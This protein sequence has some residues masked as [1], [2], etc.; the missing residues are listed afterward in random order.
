MHLLQWFFPSRGRGK[1]SLQKGKA[2]SSQG[3]GQVMG[4]S[5]MDSASA[6]AQVVVRAVGR[7]VEEKMLPYQGLR[8]LEVGWCKKDLQAS[9][10]PNVCYHRVLS[11]QEQRRVMRETASPQGTP[12]GH[13][14]TWWPF[15]TRVPECP[16]RPCQNEVPGAGPFRPHPAGPLTQALP[17]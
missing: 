17:P 5:A 16:S 12:R 11:Y 6:E 1:D 10:D 2:S 3:Q 13:N 9:V 4:R 7:I 8:V 14:Y 15:P